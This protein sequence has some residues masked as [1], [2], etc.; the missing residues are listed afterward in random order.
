MREENKRRPSPSPHGLGARGAM[1]PPAPPPPPL[2]PIQTIPE[3]VLLSDILAR[4]PPAS[5]AAVACV[6]ASWRALVDGPPQT[7]WRA[8]LVEALGSEE[9]ADA[10]AC[11]HEG[12]P[13]R[14]LYLATPHLRFDGVYA[15]RNTYIR[16]GLTEWR[17]GSCPVHVSVERGGRLDGAR[18][19]RPLAPHTRPPPLSGRHLLP[20]LP[21]PAARPRVRPAVPGALL[22]QDDARPARARRP[23]AAGG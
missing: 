3:S 13:L 23:R 19:R 14:S 1:Q 18:A 8:A 10:L 20:L 12:T 16:A 7:L 22:L 5:L 9:A 4:L 15:S 6:C 17:R 11:A 21:L 2:A